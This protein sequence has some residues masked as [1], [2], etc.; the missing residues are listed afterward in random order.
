MVVG[1]RL[2]RPDAY[3]RGKVQE[4]G[5]QARFDPF[6]APPAAS[7]EAL[8]KVRKKWALVVGIDKFRDKGVPTLDYAVKDSSDFVAF[9]KDPD[10]GRFQPDRV[11][12]LKNEEATLEGIREGLG[13]LRKKDVQQDDLVVLY[14]SSHGSARNSDPNGMS[15]IITH[16]TNPNDQAKLYATSLQMIDLVQE[17][18]REIRARRVIL[19]LDTC[20]SGGATGARGI[21][22]VWT[23]SPPQAGA[24]ASS[25]FS[26]AFQ[27]L[28]IGVGRA[29]ITSAR[30]D[31]ESF[32][33]QSLMNGFFT[34]SLIKALR[35]SQGAGT[36]GTI[37][38]KIRDE[39]ASGA[40]AIGQTQTPSSDFSEQAADI[41]IGVPE[42]D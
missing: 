28:K 39:V 4:L 15:Y 20:Y 37:F 23:A 35:E 17:I 41:V 12:Y 36:L 38:P 8:S 21:P 42:A 9:L 30:A 34:H 11:Q 7:K 6:S 14:F 1:D 2:G 31:E 29:V 19:I 10:G 26:A 27:N 16:D 18:N 24:P 32:E 3:V 22:S 33:N 25:A 40:R 13:R 5:Y